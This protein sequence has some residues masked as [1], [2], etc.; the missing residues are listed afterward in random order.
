MRYWLLMI[1]LVSPVWAGEPTGNSPEHT[2]AFRKQ[3]EDS[4]KY[5][6]IHLKED[7]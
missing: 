1:L 3:V 6:P 4:L 7:L 2:K 5:E